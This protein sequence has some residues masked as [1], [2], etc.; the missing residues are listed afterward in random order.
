MS[1]TINWTNPYQRRDGVWLRGNLHAHT[2]PGSGCGTLPAEEV[3]A[4]YE[5]AGYDFLALSDHMCLTP[6]PPTSMVTLPGIE[7]NSAS[8]EHTGVYALSSEPPAAAC[9]I[10]EQ[11]ALLA[12]LSGDDT[13]LVL[14]H[15][16]WTLRPHYHRDEL[17]RASGHDGIEIYNALIRRLDGYAISTAKWD[18]LL[19]KG[20]RTLG[21]A[22]D[23]SHVTADIGQAWI[24][25]RAAERTPAAILRAIKTGN[26]YCSG[27]VTITDIRRN[28][29]IIDIE[30][31]D[32]Q[33]IQAIGTGGCLLRSVRDR[34]MTVNL[35]D[36]NSTYVR[37]QVYGY[38]SAMAWTQP[39]FVQ[40]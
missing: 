5:R 13:L 24:A 34:A 21:F 7:W 18:Y 40:V 8:G 27:G 22:S 33:E 35:A 10:T 11:A 15:P 20:K 16:D 38:G 17:E 39:F 26:F 6:A 37:F 12:T 2:S 30:T 25:V 28:G 29:D 14:N 3:V 4:R 31:E 19:A 23:D 1:N 32:G 36:V 9:G